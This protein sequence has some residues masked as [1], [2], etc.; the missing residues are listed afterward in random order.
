MCENGANDYPECNDFPKKSSNNNKITNINENNIKKENT[1]DV[2]KNKY[3]KYK[4]KYLRLKK[5][6]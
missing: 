5:E 1:T 2:N 3:L 6:K 4:L